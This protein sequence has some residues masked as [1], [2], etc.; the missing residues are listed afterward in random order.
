M[1]VEELVERYPEIHWYEPVI[2]QH[3]SG[4]TFF[5]CRICI[6]LYGV[7]GSDMTGVPET[8]EEWIEHMAVVHGA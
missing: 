2:I 7:K 6:A 5:A 8:P 4:G 3:T 1:T